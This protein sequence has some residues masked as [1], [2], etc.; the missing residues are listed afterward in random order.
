M[1]GHFFFC[2]EFSTQKLLAYIFSLV[3]A[4]LLQL[5][6]F[7]VIDIYS[8]FIFFHTADNQVQETVNND[9]KTEST[10]RN[11]KPDEGGAVSQDRS[12]DNVFKASGA[13]SE[14]AKQVEDDKG[15]VIHNTFH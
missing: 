10:T 11:E 9:V 7:C 13:R 5:A 4:D 1:S 2:L 14:K 15:T 8:C 3:T 6:R 12:H